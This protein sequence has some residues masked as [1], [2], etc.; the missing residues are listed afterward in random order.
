M[1]GNA[2]KMPFPKD[3]FDIIT[4]V[5][6][7]EFLDAEKT[8]SEA[9]RVVKKGGLVYVENFNKIVHNLPFV[10]T[11]KHYRTNTNFRFISLAKQNRFRILKF[12]SVLVQPKL[13]FAKQLFYSIIS[14]SILKKL[15]SPVSY[16][17]L[18]KL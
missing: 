17:Y 13:S 7:I 9:S 5:D 12:G 11:S 14:I 18:K 4:Y 8:L 16:F 6:V 15:F 10:K 3:S 2:E 1:L